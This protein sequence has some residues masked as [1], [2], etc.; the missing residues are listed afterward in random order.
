MKVEKLEDL[1]HV[2]TCSVEE[3]ANLV[4]LSRTRAYQVATRCRSSNFSTFIVVPHRFMRLLD[5]SQNLKRLSKCVRKVNKSARKVN[6]HSFL[7]GQIQ[8][9]S[10]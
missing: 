9:E 10:S 8:A 1:Q 7:N 6:W 3:A 4:G 2:A 5:A